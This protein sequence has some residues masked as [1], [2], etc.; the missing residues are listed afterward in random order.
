MSSAMMKMMFGLV[1]AC[2]RAR[3][4]VEATN[5][6]PAAPLRSLRR[7]IFCGDAIA[8]PWLEGKSTS[9]MQ[10]ASVGREHSLV[11]H[12]GQR[13]MWEDGRLQ[14]GIRRFERA[15]DAVALDQ[16]G[17]FGANHM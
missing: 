3:P 8:S 11:H 1:G 15:R 17:Y 16:F 5:A 7:V 2:A 13:R 10:R 14:V 4:M 12:L 6:D 9:N